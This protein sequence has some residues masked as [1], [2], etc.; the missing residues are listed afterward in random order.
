ML[1][2][3][4]AIA[5]PG[6]EPFEEENLMEELPAEEPVGSTDPAPVYD[7][8]VFTA[9]IRR[10]QDDLAEHPIEGEK[11]IEEDMVAWFEAKQRRNEGQR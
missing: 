8:R 2:T 10:L 6:E 3:G 11:K 1:A 9:A 7:T 4:L 5:A